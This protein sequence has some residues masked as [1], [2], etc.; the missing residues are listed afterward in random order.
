MNRKLCKNKKS[1]VLQYYVKTMVCEIAINSLEIIILILQPAWSD[2]K[3]DP[4]RAHG[5]TVKVYFL[6]HLHA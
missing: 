1:P 6:K 3:I 5:N 4:A 2:V